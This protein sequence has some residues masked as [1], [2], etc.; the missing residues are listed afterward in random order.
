M[1]KDELKKLIQIGEGFTVER[2]VAVNSLY[3]LK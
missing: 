2:F 3:D 1:N